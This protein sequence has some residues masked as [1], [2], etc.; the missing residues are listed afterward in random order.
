[1]TGFVLFRLVNLYFQLFKRGAGDWSFPNLTLRLCG[2]EERTK[3]GWGIGARSQDPHLLSYQIYKT[4]NNSCYALPEPP[5]Q[6]LITCIISYIPLDF[7]LYS[8]GHG[9]FYKVRNLFT[10]AEMRLLQGQNKTD[11]NGTIKSQCNVSGDMI[12]ILY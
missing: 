3:G 9:Q 4:G 12:G 10:N 8:C 5:V 2:A 11:E 7:V 6:I 1:M